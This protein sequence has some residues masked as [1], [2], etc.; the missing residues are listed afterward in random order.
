[1][2]NEKLKVGEIKLSIYGIVITVEVVCE[3][4]ALSQ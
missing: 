4:I 3:L 1:M 2:E